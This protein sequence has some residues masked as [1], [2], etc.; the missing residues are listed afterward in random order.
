MGD[1]GYTG[2]CTWKWQT[3]QVQVYDPDNKSNAALASPVSQGSE[4]TF[5]TGESGCYNM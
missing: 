5:A 3:E 1:W 4:K 2:C